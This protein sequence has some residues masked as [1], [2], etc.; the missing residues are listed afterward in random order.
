MCVPHICLQK[1]NSLPIPYPKVSRNVYSHLS[2]KYKPHVGKYQPHGSSGFSLVLSKVHMKVLP[3]SFLPSDS[4]KNSISL[5]P[6]QEPEN[7]RT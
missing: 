7:W 4:A 3:D 1:V 2:S 6:G 5:W